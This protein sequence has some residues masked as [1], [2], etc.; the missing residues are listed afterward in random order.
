[1]T[2]GDDYN[3]TAKSISP[4]KMENVL[5]RSIMSFDTIFTNGSL[6]VFFFHIKKY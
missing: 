4:P 5:D 2:K 1:M 3:E 6:S